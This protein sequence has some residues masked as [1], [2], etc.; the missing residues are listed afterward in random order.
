[1]KRLSLLLVFSLLLLS[2]GSA[3][4]V[5]QESVLVI[6][7]EQEPSKLNPAADESFASLMENFYARDLWDWDTNREIYP[8][9]A[10]EIPSLENGMAVT[11]DN[12]NTQV[13][14]KLRQGMK[15][16][17]GEE[18]TSADC[19][20]WH[21]I[22]MD[23]A[24]FAIQRGIYVDVVESFEVVDD[25]TFILTYN[26]PFP[27]FTTRATA[28]C[29]YPEH[30][31]RPILE[32]EGTLDFASYWDGVGVVGYG[33]YTFS[34]WSVGNSVTFNKNPLWDGQEA[35]FDKVVLNFLTEPAQMQNA[36]EVGE[37]DVAF[38]FSDDLVAGYKGIAGVQVFGTPGVYGDAL[39]INMGNGGHPALTDL[40]VREAIAH[41]IDRKTLAE[42]LVGPGTQV[43]AAWHPAQFWPDDIAPLDYDVDMANQL[44]DEAGWIDSNGDSIRDKDGEE[45]IL[46][47]FTTT[48]QIRMDYQ[49]VIQEY[50]DAVGI[51][52]QLLPIP[53]GI[54]FGSFNERGVLNTGDFDLAIFALSA[55]PLS[56]FADAPSWFGC[57]GIPSIDNPD[58]NNGWGF[59][60][61][62]FDTK[63]AL[64]GV[65]VDPVQR[66]AYAHDAI[67]AFVNAQFWEGLYLRPQWYAFNTD[68]LDFETVQDVGTLSANYFQKVEYWQPAQ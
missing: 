40:R 35:A 42:E 48:R 7:W 47:F 63:D 22:R 37:I 50:L 61:E 56:P 8:V 31:L 38:N 43:P 36:M 21:E 64:V 34:E 39:W 32:A 45:L 5:A 54:L 23:P 57:G 53:S 9:M 4:V 15:W 66:L 46:R 20:F 68:R 52:T 58:G 49:V 67:R 12:G 55:D 13:T 27:D 1:M 24:T 60:S 59:C 41:A 6:G 11:L 26:T 33:P 2:L 29:A 14:Y 62:E 19:E 16:S 65:T 51:S 28:S 18:I 17:D 25:Y 44:L 30:I 10:A 3:I